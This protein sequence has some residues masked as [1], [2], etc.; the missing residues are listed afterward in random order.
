MTPKTHEISLGTTAFNQITQNSY[1]I[2]EATGINQNDYI[3]YKQV[4]SI[5]NEFAETGLFQMT[6]VTNI[7]Q[8]EGLKDGYVLIVFNK[9]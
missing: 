7:I 4:E 3:L 8:N 5:G 6:Q 9:L 2:I 1:T